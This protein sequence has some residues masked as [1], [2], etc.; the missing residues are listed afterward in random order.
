MANAAKRQTELLGVA[1]AWWRASAGENKCSGARLAAAK[2]AALRIGG[3]RSAAGGRKSAAG[4]DFW[5]KQRSA[6]NAKTSAAYGELAVMICGYYRA[7]LNAVMAKAGGKA[8]ILSGEN[9]NMCG[10]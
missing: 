7:V 3:G 9:I 2:D 5:A 1:W 4:K 8:K 6:E 10:R